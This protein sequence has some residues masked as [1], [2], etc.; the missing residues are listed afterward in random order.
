MGHPSDGEAWKVLNR[1]DAEFASD[2][3]NVCFGSTSSSLTSR[4]SQIHLNYEMME[5]HLR[6]TQDVLAME[7]ENHR[8]TQESVN[9]FHAQIQGF[10]SVRNKNKFIPFLIFSDIYVCKNF[11]RYRP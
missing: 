5:N 3:R 1:F 8:E 9:A 7:Q 11:L 2:T 6:T 10:M 4:I